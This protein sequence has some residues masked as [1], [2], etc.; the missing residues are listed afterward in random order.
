MP[1]IH[2]HGDLRACGAT[3]IVS[4]Q[5]TVYVNGKLAAVEGDKCSHGNGD[6]IASNNESKLFINGKQV[7]TLGATAAPD[8]NGHTN[9]QPTTGSD[10]GFGL[11]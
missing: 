4:G 10:T 7:I 3:T 2:R 1:A 5:S 11:V 6:L 9:T 8:L